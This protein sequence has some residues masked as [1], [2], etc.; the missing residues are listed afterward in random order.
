MKSMVVLLDLL[1]VEK[2]AFCEVALSV[3]KLDKKGA[4]MMD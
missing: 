1:S 4:E 3:D 2:T